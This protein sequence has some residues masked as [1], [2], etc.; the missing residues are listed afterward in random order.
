MLLL[1]G[2]LTHYIHIILYNESVEEEVGQK[3]SRAIA[4]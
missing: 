2:I 1:D 4:R 3:L